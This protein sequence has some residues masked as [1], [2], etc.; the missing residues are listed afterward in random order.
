MGVAHKAS[1]FQDTVL[2][3]KYMQDKDYLLK[4]YFE[5]FGFKNQKR[6]RKN[7]SFTRP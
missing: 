2:V 3:L 1:A 7:I 4:T 5:I 6:S